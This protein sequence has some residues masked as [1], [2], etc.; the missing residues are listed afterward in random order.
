M[1]KNILGIV[2]FFIISSN[3]FAEGWCTIKS[4]FKVITNGI[5][6]DRVWIYGSF[7]NLDQVHWLQIANDTMGKSNVSLALA[8]QVAGKRIQIFLDGADETCENID[9][10]YANMRHLQLID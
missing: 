10:S 7:E 9:A 1:S 8:A 2:C 3:L 4:D 6:T 5:K